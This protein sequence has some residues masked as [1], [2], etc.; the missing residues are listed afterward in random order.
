MPT[1]YNRDGGEEH[2]CWASLSDRGIRSV[3]GHCGVRLPEHRSQDYE[4]FVAKKKR[5]EPKFSIATPYLLAD[6]VMPET[7]WAQKQSRSPQKV[8]PSES[9]LPPPSPLTVGPRRWLSRDDGSGY[10]P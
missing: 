5:E 2:S 8:E 7:N 3:R 10:G 4:P 9:R 6:L 1:S